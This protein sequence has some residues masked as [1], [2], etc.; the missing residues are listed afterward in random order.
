MNISKYFWDLKEEALKETK[1]ILKNTEH[2]K[3]NIRIVTFLS[4]CDKPK[5]LFSIIPEKKFVEVWPGIRTYWAKRIQQSDFRDWWETI[6]EQLLEKYRHKQKKVK[7]KTP[8][9]FR[10]IG[11]VIKEARIEKGLSQKHLAL[12]IGMKQ[13]DISG[14]EEGKKNITLFTLIRLCKIL[15]IKRIDIS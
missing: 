4:R 14:I 7:G 12:S 10:K 5:E 13:P 3:F 11:R 1:K 6:Y 8:S 15:G 2:H 9:F